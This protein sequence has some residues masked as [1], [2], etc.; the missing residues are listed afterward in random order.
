MN[1]DRP[2]QVYPNEAPP[3]FYAMPK[4]LL[5]D[6]YGQSTV[7]NYCNA[8]DYRPQCNPAHRCASYPV[9]RTSDGAVLERADGVSV[10]FK[11]R[12]MV[13]AA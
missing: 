7:G 1:T 12:Q 11:A 4:A 10:V 9:T 5:N 2:N 6:R 13:I 3:G 8:C